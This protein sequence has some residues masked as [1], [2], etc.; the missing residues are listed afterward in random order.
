MEG[1]EG[2]EREEG[3]KEGKMERRTEEGNAHLILVF[4]IMVFLYF[5]IFLLKSLRYVFFMLLQY[6]INTSVSCMV[7]Y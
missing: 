1:R 3:R 5:Q 7:L 2:G 4:K 6:F